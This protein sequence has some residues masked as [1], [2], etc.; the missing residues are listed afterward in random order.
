MKKETRSGSTLDGESG[1]RTL[2]ICHDNLAVSLPETG[3][4]FALDPMPGVYF[5]RNL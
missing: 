4:K 3:D 2:I 5:V 1:T